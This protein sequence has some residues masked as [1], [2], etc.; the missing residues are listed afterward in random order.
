MN[1]KVLITI[2]V[3]TLLFLLGDSVLAA[4]TGSCP[5]DYRCTGGVVYYTEKYCEVND[6]GFC[7]TVSGTKPFYCST[8]SCR[9]SGY[10][11]VCTTLTPPCY[12]RYTNAHV[13]CCEKCTSGCG[14][15]S[16]KGTYYSSHPGGNYYISGYCPCTRS[17]CTSYTGF[18]YS[19]DP[20]TSC[21]CG[22]LSTS[23]QGAGSKT[24]TCPDGCG[25]TAS[26]TCYCS[27][28]DLDLLNMM[29]VQTNV[30]YLELE[31]VTV[32]KHVH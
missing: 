30:E 29:T 21:Y 20:Y 6:A 15:C 1:K 26:S 2:F 28:C 12:S 13:D 8:S 19:C 22:S 32:K 5:S 25:G 4:V 3:L 16:P 23:N 9:I 17:N 14:S 7:E 10:Q 18:C 24:I 27:P 31:H 11:E